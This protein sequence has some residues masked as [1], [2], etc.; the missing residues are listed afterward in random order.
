M[1]EDGLVF[2]G[3]DASTGGY[4]YA[5]KT[6][7]EIAALAR[8][9]QPEADKGHLA[10]LRN[11]V[12]RLRSPSRGVAEGINPLDLAQTG[13]AVL[14][15]FVSD[16]EAQTR[17]AAIL[18]ALRPLL[19]RRKAQASRINPS[20]YRE[21]TGVDAYRPKE[22]KR[23]WL[24]RHGA[25][26]AS[27]AHP[28]KVP[29]YILIVADPEAIPF[30]FQ[31]QLDV[32][33][34]VGRLD[35]DTVEEYARYAQSV[36]DAETDPPARPRR[37]AFFGVRNDDDAA[38]QSSADHLVRPLAAAFAANPAAGPAGTPWEFPT[39]LAADATKSRLARLLGGQDTPA[40]LFTASH[41]VGFPNGGDRQF[42]N[43]GALLCQDWP[44]PTLGSGRPVPDTCFFAAGDV[45]A[46]ADLHGLISFH[47]ACY[48]LGTPRLDDFPD[49]AAGKR[50]GELA[51]RAFTAGLPRRL[52]AHP[53]GG[54]LA[55]IGHVDRAWG[56][57]FSWPRAGEQILTFQDV[58][59]RL[60][61][62]HPVG[63][64]TEPLNVRY[65]AMSTELSDSLQ[66]EKLGAPLP[67]AVLAGLW[68]ANNDARG[69]VV[70]GDPAVRLCLGPVDDPADTGEAASLVDVGPAPVVEVTRGGAAVR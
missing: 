3:V 22:A 14:V 56:Y 51:P 25:A 21:Y 29:Y 66:D 16:P 43:Q 53:K 38:T 61:A 12:R 28:K 47:F 36:V 35:F 37:A 41:G 44:G 39:V 1:A 49:L 26:P 18:D 62:G 5:P 52:L 58:L 27:P 17:Q 55:V 45:A 68:T 46:D 15:P 63:S 31:Y 60:F 4:L 13:W 20:Y 30:R 34:A 69:Y 9:I 42:Q 54:A 24:A 59:M 8:G 48:G 23:D 57:S 50:P 2:N 40:L 6:P 19:D 7:E 64:A 32:E 65:A 70:L 10:T 67:P 33:Y 11:W